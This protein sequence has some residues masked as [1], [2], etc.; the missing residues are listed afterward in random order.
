MRGAG[1]QPA[2]AHRAALV[3]N[4]E[5]PAGSRLRADNRQPGDASRCLSIPL[6]LLLTLALASAQ[7]PPKQAD[8]K[9]DPHAL[10]YDNT[11]MLPGLPYR[12]HDI[13]RPHPRIVET[14]PRPGDPPSDAIV[15]FNGKDL[16][17]WN[18]GRRR[19]SIAEPAA[20]KVE[21]GYFEAVPGK[22]DIAT[23]EAFGD[24]QLHLEWSPP[25]EVHGSSQNRGNSGII[26]EG[27]Y[28]VQILD[29]WQNPTYADGQAGAIYGEWPPLVNPVHKPGEWNYY[30]I[31]FEAPKFE[32]EN[33]VKPGYLTVF[34]NGVLLHNRKEVM[35]VT[36]HAQLP[37]YTPHPAEDF[38]ILQNHNGSDR[39]RNIWVRRL[40]GYDQPEK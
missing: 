24:I 21:N 22:G 13:N 28:E 16:S 32:G 33:L 3:F 38:L 36:A 11:P 6:A 4:T 19:N 25:A 9:A 8:K 18:A 20:W 31:V 17:Q 27:R 12:V 39:F 14:P 35:G 30:D 5:E 15:L 40:T 26:F 34:L 29:S 2:A 7:E 1:Y 10:G 37:K 23:K